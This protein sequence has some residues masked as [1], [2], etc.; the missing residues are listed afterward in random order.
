MGDAG[1]PLTVVDAHLRVKGVPHLRIADA[2][3]FPSALGVNPQITV[4]TSAI[5]IARGTA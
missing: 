1:D 5:T 3:I 4:M 2:S